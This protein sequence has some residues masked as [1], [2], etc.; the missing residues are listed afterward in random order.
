[1]SPRDQAVRYLAKAA[2]DEA[3]LDEVIGT[4]RVSD[5]VVGFH[6]QQAAE[7]LLKALLAGLGI[8]FRRTMVCSGRCKPEWTNHIVR[9]FERPRPEGID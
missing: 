5:E 2:L 8:S 4:D 6:C 9:S 3:L 7:K 1:M